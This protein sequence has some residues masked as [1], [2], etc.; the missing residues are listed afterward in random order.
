VSDCRWRSHNGLLRTPF[1]P[2]A[3]RGAEAPIRPFR[4]LVRSYA[5]AVGAGAWQLAQVNVA[6]LRAPIDSPEVAEFVALLEPVNAVADGAPGF[7]WRLQTED[8]DATAIRAFDDDRIIVN[9]SVW[10]SVEA[11]GEFVYRSR[12]LDVLRRRRDWFD[13]ME[14]SFLALWWT[15]SGSRPSVKEAKRRLE[16]LDRHGPTAEAFTFK[17]PFPAP[18]ASVEVERD[19]RWFCPAG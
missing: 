8:G 16:M 13:R 1:R 5:A 19:D 2:P 3:V 17:V 9:M 11:L 6:R 7:V 12:H 10:E 15:P 4:R 18:D 14:S